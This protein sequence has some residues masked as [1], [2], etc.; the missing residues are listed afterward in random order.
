MTRGGAVY[1]LTNKNRTALYI[2]VTSDLRKRIYE[3]KSSKDSS[4]FTSRYNITSL[5]YYEG[6]H[7]IEE[8][9]ARE[10][11]LK[12]GSRKKKEDLVNSVNPKWKDLYN[13][14]LEW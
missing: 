3:H 10:K 11:Q 5:V 7:N 12:A 8:A 9:I 6:F 13:E 2:G 14:V 1:I 4:S